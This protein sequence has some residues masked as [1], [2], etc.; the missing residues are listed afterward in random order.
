MA[1]LS[2]AYY[3]SLS[4]LR[5]R[6]VL[7]LD[8]A[9]KDQ[10]DRTWSFWEQGA[11]PF[12]SI[13]FRTWDTVDFYGTTLS[14]P[15]DLGTYRYKLLRGIDFYTFVQEHLRQFPNIEFRQATINRVADTPQGGFVIADDEPY[16]ADYVFD[17]TY[18]LRLNLPERHNLLQ[19]FKGWI[20]RTQ[21][22]CFD[23]QHP[24]MMD[25]RVAQQGDCR[26]LYVLPFDTQTA[27]VEYTIFNDHLLSETD[28][29]TALRTYIDQFLDAGTYQ[30]SETEFGVIPMSDEQAPDRPAEHLIRIGTSG[31]YTKPST[32][33]TFQRTQQ[34]LRELVQNLAEMG[35]PIR[36]K[37]RLRVFF[38]GYLDSVLLNVLQYKRHPADD[39][40]TRLYEH[41]PPSQIFRFL[42]EDTTFWEDIRIMQTVP[43][44]PF[45]VGAFDVMRKRLF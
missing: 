41:N 6:S 29:E 21:K 42:D 36:K 10:N 26:F 32:G 11:G 2:L 27:L 23:V 38:K 33:Y 24:R 15:L 44:G 19:H 43:L 14:G 30:I 37:S 40:F 13:L 5:N 3:L 16:M 22:P 4:P 8:K 25:F 35:Q 7:V 1:G 31:G 17:S 34:Y 20:I 9:V 45:L 18:A 28:Y 39:I 12:E